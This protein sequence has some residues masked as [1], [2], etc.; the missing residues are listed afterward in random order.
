MRSPA[1]YLTAALT[2]LGFCPCCL[3]CQ[4]ALETYQRICADCFKDLP[5]I[6]AACR[7]CA[8]PLCVAN[9]T[10]GQC[11]QHPP[12]WDRLWV[13]LDYVFPVEKLILGGK[14][15]EGLH[16]LRLLAE[17]FIDYWRKQDAI[18]PDFLLPV[19]LHPKRLRERGYNQALELARV[20]GRELNIPIVHAS[21]RTRA[22]VAQTSLNAQQRLRNVKHAFTVHK[23]FSG[24][25]VAIVDDVY[26]T[27]ST[28]A[29]L[30]AVLR[31]AGAAHIDVYTMARSL[32]HT[33]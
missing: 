9:E 31:G 32:G 10:C 15:S 19:P 16:H 4:Q 26:T 5:F 2:Q 1:T 30:S 18:K 24:A 22:T 12:P 17:L 8:R 21:E 27:G 6:D 23:D 14:F 11:Q 13:A 3:L 33:H 28:V 20:I 29:A 7:Y 25:R